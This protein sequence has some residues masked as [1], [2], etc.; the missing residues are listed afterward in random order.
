MIEDSNPKATI[1]VPGALSI[2]IGGIVGG[3]FF[4]TFGLTIAGAKGATP[5]SFLIA[6]LI[7]L[8]TAYSY[9]ALTLRYPG[10]GGTVK[11]I[12][13]AFGSGKLAASINVLLVLSYVAIM[14]VYASALASYSVPYLPEHLHPIA[15]HVISSLAIIAFGFVNFA[16]PALGR[17]WKPSSTLVSLGY[18][19]CSSWRDSRSATSTGRG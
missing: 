6:G 12:I 18:L 14:S 19:R 1:G 11:F 5:I 2:G 17:G 16:G 3:G 9:I 15:S 7:A 8:V 10:P 13:T 4:A